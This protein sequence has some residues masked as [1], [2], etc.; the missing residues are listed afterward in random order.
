MGTVYKAYD[1]LE[2]RTV[3]VK[4]M[5][6]RHVG[7][8]E[9][10]LA[11][12]GEFRLESTDLYAIGVIGY[13]LLTGR[14]PLTGNRKDIL[15]GHLAIVPAEPKAVRADIPDSLNTFIVKLLE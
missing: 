6:S 15:Q 3:A 13:Q 10:L 12:K 7:S 8:A 11:F 5:I 14:P 2:A 4:R 1:A 9:A